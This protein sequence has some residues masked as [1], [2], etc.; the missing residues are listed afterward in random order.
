[1]SLESVAQ[2]GSEPG[3][4]VQCPIDGDAQCDA[5]GD[6][7]ADIDGLSGP[8]EQSEDDADG[9]Q[10][11]QHGQD[12]GGRVTEQDHH[13]D[14][15]DAKG[16]SKT[17]DQAVENGLLSFQEDGHHAGD[18]VA[19]ARMSLDHAL[20]DIVEVTGSLVVGQATVVVVG[21]DRDL[22]GDPPQF[23]SGLVEFLVAG[24]F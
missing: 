15:D 17:P 14:G 16:Q 22:S 24:D 12:T 5:G 6:H 13:H 20:D 21:H 2:S 23:V 18:H 4:Q 8:A 11:G 3:D 1:M 9:H 10:V 19:A 7:G